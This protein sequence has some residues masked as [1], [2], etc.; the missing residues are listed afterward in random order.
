MDDT[1][2]SEFQSLKTVNQTTLSIRRR[3]ERFNGREI[4]QDER[5]EI[6]LLPLNMS[7]PLWLVA[8]RND[9]NT[10][11]LRPSFCVNCAV[12]DYTG[13]MWL[14]NLAGEKSSSMTCKLN[15]VGKDDH[16]EFYY[17]KHFDFGRFNPC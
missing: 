8:T 15:L 12:N 4:G 7:A 1:T 9:E 3:I 13:K 16:D 17:H 2:Y 6:Q 14:E 11:Y 5:F 10:I